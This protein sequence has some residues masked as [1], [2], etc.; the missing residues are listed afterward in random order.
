MYFAFEIWHNLNNYLEGK[1]IYN[2]HHKKK[3]K[4]NLII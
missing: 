2:T 4:A 3:T 1:N